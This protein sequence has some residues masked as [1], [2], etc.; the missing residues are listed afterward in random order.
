MN[1][2]KS[3]AV[4]ALL[5]AASSLLFAADKPAA[6]KGGEAFNGTWKIDAAQSKLSPKPM[7][8]YIANG[9]YHCESCSP[10]IVV[11]ADGADHAVTGERYDTLAVKVVDDHT[12]QRT[13]KKAG[14]VMFEETLAVSKDGKLLTAKITSHPMNGGAAI[15]TQAAAKRVGVAP[16]GVQAT[17]GDWQLLNFSQSSN[18]LTF[19]YKVNGDQL[20]MTDP[21]GVSY[22]ANLDGTEAPVTGAYDFDTVSIKRI[23]PDT[24]EETDKRAGQVV[25]VSKIT[26]HGKTMTI[27]DTSKPA[28]RTSTYIAHKVG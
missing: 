11:A 12:I 3:F 19:T 2:M 5:V 7:V 15:T 26:V 18:G 25:D 20:T 21:N 10:V 13:A 27:E 8:F 4:G 6:A 16:S 14:N 23:G 22:T 28:E 24:I 9:W 1:T 17:S